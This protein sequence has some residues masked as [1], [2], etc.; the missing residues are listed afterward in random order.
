MN[1]ILTELN[2]VKATGIARQP[3]L[4][5]VDLIPFRLDWNVMLDFGNH[6]FLSWIS[7]D[8]SG[9]WSGET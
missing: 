8:L 2:Y 9:H 4:Q 5:R 7:Q 1:E 3:V 6:N